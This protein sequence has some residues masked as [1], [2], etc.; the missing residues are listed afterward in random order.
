M[1][2]KVDELIFERKHRFRVLQNLLTPCP[3]L[4]TG[5]NPKVVI[6]VVNQQ[7]LLENFS[8]DVNFFPF[9]K[10]PLLR[11][12]RVRKCR[13]RRQLSSIPEIQK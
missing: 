8:Q 2:K 5:V 1:I 9:H 7:P 6:E 12:D 4:V 13:R 3:P 10:V 11:P